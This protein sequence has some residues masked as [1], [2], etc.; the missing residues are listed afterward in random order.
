[1]CKYR[2]QD[3]FT[4][5][6]RHGGRIIGPKTANTFDGGAWVAQRS[7]Q[8]TAIVI[9]PALFLSCIERARSQTPAAPVGE[10]EKIAKTY[11]IGVLT[12][13][14]RFPVKTTHGPIDGKNAN[15]NELQDYTRLF[16]REFALYP[17]HLVQRSQ[18]RRVVLCSELSFVSQRRNAIPDFEHATLYLDVNRG[19]YSKSY[20][21]KVIH[22]EFF[23]VIDYR[24]DGSVYEDDRWASLNPDPFKYG[25][26]GRAAQ[27]LPETSVLTNKFPGFLNHYS[28]T[29]V[30]EDKAELFANL[31]VDLEY[32]EERARQDR[33]I[34]AKVQRMQNLLVRF[35]PAM[36][37][38]FWEKVRKMKRADK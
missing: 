30:E 1:M 17:P 27:V 16:A 28:T 7:Y 3:L 4:W 32:V 26:G 37:D 19:T 15:G 25:T 5:T 12:A 14:L 34:H 33:V 38:T 10:L 18:L 6:L 20:L 35:C 9:I 11:K 29:A 2:A 31:L 8:F 22:H 13:D 23:H 21:R 24:D 36:D